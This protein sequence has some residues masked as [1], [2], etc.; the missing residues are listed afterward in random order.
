MG[1]GLF[2]AWLIAHHKDGTWIICRCTGPARRHVRSSPSMIHLHPSLRVL[3]RPRQS[4]V[5]LAA[6][7]KIEQAR[8]K[9]NFSSFPLVQSPSPCARHAGARSGC[10]QI[11]TPF[12]WLSELVVLTRAFLDV[13]MGE[14]P[15]AWKMRLVLACQTS[16]W[17]RSKA[18]ISS[19]LCAAPG[20]S[21]NAETS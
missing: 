17:F 8:G 4:P 16:T 10:P 1:L 6:W 19:G 12:L 3:A 5:R 9:G 2:P 15:L 13:H 11:P 20:P 18:K 21:A 7:P 14:F